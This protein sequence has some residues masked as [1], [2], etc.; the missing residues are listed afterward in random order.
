MIFDWRTGAP[1]G[2]VDPEI[3]F[4]DTKTNLR[5][6]RKVCKECLF[7]APCALWA[8]RHKLDDGI[9]GGLDGDGRK[10][11]ADELNIQMEQEEAA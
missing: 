5:Q 4:S 7:K 6:A 9:W 10:I 11:L 1:C 2:Q 8:I 3:F